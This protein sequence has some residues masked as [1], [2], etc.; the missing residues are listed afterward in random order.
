MMQSSSLITRIS[1]NPYRYDHIKAEM[2]KEHAQ[3]PEQTLKSGDRLSD[4]HLSSIDG[5]MQSTQALWSGKPILL[6]MGSLSCPM[7]TASMP[8]VLQLYKEFGRKVDFVLLYVREAHPGEKIPQPKTLDVKRTH[9]AALVEHS[10]VPFQVLVDDID[11]TLHQRLGGMP[12][13]AFLFASSGVVVFRALW[14]GDIS[15]VR[16][17]LESL[18]AGEPLRETQSERKLRPMTQG[19]GLMDDALERAGES[20]RADVRREVPMMAFLSK[21]ASVFQPLKPLQRGVTAMAVVGL[22]AVVVVAGIGAVLFGH[23]DG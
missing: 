5:T 16:S 14:I 4:F 19:L 6:I 21:L 18:I 11:G 9:A 13:G 22:L 20:A 3:F 12:N 8:D 7:T 2:F 17:A 15:G 10:S 23:S 1:P